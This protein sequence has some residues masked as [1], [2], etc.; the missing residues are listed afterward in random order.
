MFMSNEE[1]SLETTGIDI[2]LSSVVGG[3][4]L[5]VCLFACGRSKL[6]AYSREFW[7]GKK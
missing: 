4:G 3:F 2:S 7:Q 1:L 6:F 5:F